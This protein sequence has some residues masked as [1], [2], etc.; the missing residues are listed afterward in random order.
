MLEKCLQTL[1][2]PLVPLITLLTCSRKKGD[3]YIEWFRVQNDGY[4]KRLS[5]NGEDDIYMLWKEMNGCYKAKLVIFSEF[6]DLALDDVGSCIEVNFTPVRNDGARGISQRIISDIIMPG[7]L[8]GHTNYLQ[9]LSQ[10]I[11]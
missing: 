5:A 10:S 3:C 1:T 11:V 8:F 4:K 7:M 2:C 9:I 6:L